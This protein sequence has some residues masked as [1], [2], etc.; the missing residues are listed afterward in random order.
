MERLEEGLRHVGHLHERMQGLLAAVLAVGSDLDLEA[1][2]RQIVESAVSLSEATYGALGVVGE[3]GGLSRFIT[4]GVDEK[5]IAEIG[6]YPEGR[7]ILGLLI[8]E[9]VP[10]RLHDLGKH[11]DSYGFPENHPPMTSFLGVPVRV[12]DEVF[13]NLYLTEKRGGG[14]F[15]G[16]DEE[17]VTA[18]ARA[19]GVAIE[20]ARL[21]H[22][23]R[24]ATEAFQRRLLPDLPR[25][26]G[27][28]LEARYEPSSDA[29]R[30]GGDWYDL[31][32]LPDK[33]PCLMVGDVMGHGLEA[34]AVMSQIS[35][36][37]RV[38]AFDEEEPPSRILHRLDEVLHALHG[39]P[40]ATVIVVRLEPAPGGRTLHWAAA[41]HPPP[42]VVTPG[43]RPRYLVGEPGPP[44]GVDP[45]LPRGDHREDLPA[46]SSV[47]LYTDG[48]VET[49]GRSLET[50]MA[51]AAELAAEYAAAP[52]PDM[53]DALLRRSTAS[54]QYDDIALLA[55]RV[56]DQSRIKGTT[57]R[58]QAR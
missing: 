26:A 1:V 41:G 11:P 58:P 24:Q 42:L 33:V 27:L 47:L 3:D 28:E 17:I 19:A 7:G 30:I 49:R 48:L 10:L 32:R 55:A 21:Y 15:T 23:L 50:G 2:L 39:A 14:D 56:T 57:S 36:M 4:V 35:N 5:T 22:R 9:P 43:R 37:L 38:I 20:N 6:P 45:D 51:E 12:R 52:L 44:L 40:M 8:R 54:G 25:L 46:G 34:A 29:P 18:L 53:C 13:G 16:D 31:I